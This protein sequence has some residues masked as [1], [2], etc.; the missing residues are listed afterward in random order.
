MAKIDKITVDNT[1]YD[2]VS[3]DNLPV[4]TEV[5]IDDNAT[6]PTGW[7]EIDDPSAYSETEQVI[8]KWINRKT[9]I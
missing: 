3:G 9:Y 2:I 7:E 8:G 5:D 4:G 6:I 1:E